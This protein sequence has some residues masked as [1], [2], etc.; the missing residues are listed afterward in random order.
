M[1]TFALFVAFAAGS[2]TVH[3]Q[4]YVDFRNRVITSSTP[5]V[6]PVYGVNPLAPTLRISGQATTNGGT[7]V[8]NGCPLP[9]G[10]TYTASL[11]AAPV[12]QGIQPQIV[13]PP[14]FQLLV[15]TPFRT[16]S[17][18]RSF[19]LPLASA[20]EVP[21]VTQSGTPVQC[22]RRIEWCR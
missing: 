1:K 4:A 7:A 2:A 3:A 16:S 9:G 8:Y 10:T 15:T 12:Q 6:A 14:D 18:L 17:T 20:V 5:L 11:W 13:L 21:F 19:W 22:S